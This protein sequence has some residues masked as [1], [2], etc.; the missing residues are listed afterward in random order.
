M[1]AEGLPSSRP[2]IRWMRPIALGVE[3]VAGEPVEP[4]GGEDGDTAGGDAA[5]QRRA[6]PPRPRRARSRRPRHRPAPDRPPA[7]S[8]RGRG[9]SR[10]SSEARLP[11]QLGNLLGLPLPHLQRQRPPSLLGHPGNEHGP[12]R[13]IASRPSGPASSA[14]RGSHCVTSGC[15][16]GQ[17][18]SATYG[19]LA[20]D[21]GRSSRPPGPSPRGSGRAPPGRAA[22]RSLAPPPAHRRGVGRGHL[23]L[24][25]LVGDRQGDRAG[26]GADVEHRAP[27]R[28]SSAS[29]TSSSVSGR[30]ISTRRSTASS[31][32]R[33]PLRPTM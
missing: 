19:R 3:R 14:S 15:S 12:G 21:R 23:A 11:H 31:M 16:E 32:R 30:G 17:S 6:A 20:S 13:R 26:A 25:Q 33:N 4:V 5:L 2:L 8:R 9:G 22:R 24:R 18:R 7:R 28:S 29:S 1:T 10:I 27:A